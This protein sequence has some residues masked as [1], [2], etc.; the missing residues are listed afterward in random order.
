MRIRIMIRGQRQEKNN[1][2][3]IGER[4]VFLVIRFCAGAHKTANYCTCDPLQ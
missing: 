2:K 3:S 1:I 4:K